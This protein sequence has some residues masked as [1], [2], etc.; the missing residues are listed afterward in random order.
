MQKRRL[1]ELSARPTF[2]S[3][4]RPLALL[5]LS[6]AEY[7][8][9][10]SGDPSRGR[11]HRWDGMTFVPTTMQVMLRFYIVGSITNYNAGKEL[12]K[13][14]IRTSQETISVQATDVAW[15]L[16]LLLYQQGSS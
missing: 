5:I 11:V 12:A 10:V 7:W 14:V 6:D 8:I 2:K 3:A 4:A 1:A 9:D 13:K 15:I 16:G